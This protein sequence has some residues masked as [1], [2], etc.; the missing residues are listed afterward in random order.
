MNVRFLFLVYF[1][2]FIYIFITISHFFWF[3]NKEKKTKNKK[4]IQNK[5]NRKTK[6]YRNNNCGNWKIIKQWKRKRNNKCLFVKWFFIKSNW[7][8]RKKTKKYRWNNFR[9]FDIY[10]LNLFKCSVSEINGLNIR[11]HFDNC[12]KWSLNYKILNSIWISTY[13]YPFCSY[14]FYSSESRLISKQWE[15]NCNK[16][17]LIKTKHWNIIIKNYDFV[18]K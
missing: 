2:I 5:I 1:I 10:F 12:Y 7:R 17:S 11:K 15:K 8:E 4:K 13:F 18:F 3:A 6:I 16:I 14:F 9:R